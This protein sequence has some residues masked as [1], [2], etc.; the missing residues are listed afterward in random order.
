MSKE[1]YENFEIGQDITCPYCGKAYEPSYE[2]TY[3]G[4]VCVECYKED[5]VQEVVCDECG[6]K[7]TVRPILN[8]DYETNTIDGEMT[9]EEYEKKEWYKSR[10]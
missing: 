4:D 9:E 7:F 10:K 5:E 8:W 3:I 6:K 1:W 2:E